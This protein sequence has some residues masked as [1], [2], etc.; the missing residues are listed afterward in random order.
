LPTYV[1]PARH[2]CKF[3]RFRFTAKSRLVR[4]LTA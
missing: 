3:R 4:R 2:D 1:D